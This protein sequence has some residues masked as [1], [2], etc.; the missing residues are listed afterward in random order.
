MTIF[1]ER[2]LLVF[3]SHEPFFRFCLPCLLLQGRDSVSLVGIHPGL[4]LSRKAGGGIPPPSPQP[5]HHELPG[6]RLL[7][8]GHGWQ[9]RC[10]RCF[11]PVG[12]K[13]L[14]CPVLCKPPA[15][16]E[17]PHRRENTRDVMPNSFLWPRG[18]PRVA[19][20]YLQ[21]FEYPKGPLFPAT[22]LWNSSMYPWCLYTTVLGAFDQD[23]H[24]KVSPR[25]SHSD[26]QYLQPGW[27][28]RAT[29]HGACKNPHCS[30]GD[31]PQNKQGVRG[32]QSPAGEKGSLKVSSPTPCPNHGQIRPVLTQT[33]F[34]KPR[35]YWL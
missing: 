16:P 3:S 34:R 26:L 7:S 27:W 23:G 32:L 17:S 4:D 10:G 28:E 11:K 1:D 35:Y 14:P 18:F 9:L 24:F 31:Q 5:P 29:A 19:H 30:T 13:A 6:L 33:C 15:F 22:S 8:C 21:T 25:T 12:R 20:T 2:S